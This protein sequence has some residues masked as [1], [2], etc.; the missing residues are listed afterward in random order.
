M[1]SCLMRLLGLVVWK[2]HLRFHQIVIIRVNRPTKAVESKSKVFWME[3]KRTSN[4]QTTKAQSE[5]NGDGENTQ[6]GKKQPSTRDVTAELQSNIS[7]N[8]DCRLPNHFCFHYIHFPRT[9][10]QTH[11]SPAFPAHRNS[12]WWIQITFVLLFVCCIFLFQLEV[13]LNNVRISL[14]LFTRSPMNS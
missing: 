6:L 7:L 2:C 4:Q 3:T 8:P 12:P 9:A 14:P 13:S 11:F 1:V 5:G 10:P